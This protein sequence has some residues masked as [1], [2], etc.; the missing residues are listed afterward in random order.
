MVIVTIDLKYTGTGTVR[1]V[2]IIETNITIIRHANFYKLSTTGSLRLRLRN[3]GIKTV[4]TIIS[5]IFQNFFFLLVKDMRRVYNV[6]CL[7]SLL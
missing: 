5:Y 7:P 6:M 2:I 4:L 3:T 1:T